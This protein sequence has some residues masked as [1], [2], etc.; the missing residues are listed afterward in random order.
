MPFF[1]KQDCKILAAKCR[2]QKPMLGV[3]I[4]SGG[5]NADMKRCSPCWRF[6]SINRRALPDTRDWTHRTG[7]RSSGVWRRAPADSVRK[8]PDK[9]WTYDILIYIWY[10]HIIW[11]NSKGLAELKKC[12]NLLLL[13]LLQESSANKWLFSDLSPADTWEKR[14]NRRNT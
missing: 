7:E 4:L 11:R 13:H 8:T 3:L 5:I 14:R 6:C 12:M 9:Q 2:G 10:F 1:L